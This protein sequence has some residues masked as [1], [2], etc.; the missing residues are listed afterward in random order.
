M[1]LP[2]FSAFSQFR[3]PSEFSIA[4]GLVFLPYSN[5]WI[6][7]KNIIICFFLLVNEY[8]N[9]INSQIIYCLNYLNFWNKTVAV[10]F[11]C[12]LLF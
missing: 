12:L 6:L 4:E 1:N 10:L 7:L 5:W 3:K 11:L 2:R 9:V 8:S